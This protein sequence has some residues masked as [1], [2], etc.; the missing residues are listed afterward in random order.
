MLSLYKFLESFLEAFFAESGAVK[1]SVD[2]YKCDLLDF[3]SFVK[4]KSL[5]NID[6]EDVRGFVR[7]LKF[8]ELSARSISRKISALRRFFDF[9][10]SEKYI[11]KNPALMVDLPKFQNKLPNILSIEEII[12]LI[13]Y[14]R[15]DRSN[16]GIRLLAM[17]SLLYASGLRVSEL[18]TLKIDNLVFNYS[19]KIL[20]NHFNVKGKGGRDRIVVINLEAKNAL[21]DYIK[22]KD[23]FINNRFLFSSK[24]KLG[25]MT[26]QN[27]ALLLKKAGDNISIDRNRIS[28]HI[29]RHSFASHLLE[30]GADL[31]VIQELLG[32][33]DVAT[34]QIYTHL[35]C[36]HLKK[37]IDECHPLS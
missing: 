3:I 14:L 34:T 4:D 26:R 33:V 20:Q 19:T 17:V 37:I 1:N 25:H 8:K 9:L 23:K 5:M 6:I 21:E 36:S 10:I 13:S 28:P 27:F 22:I 12:E 18:V 24:S 11:T 16:E 7:Y 35:D 31:R 15:M 2:A 32:H 30:N 29:L